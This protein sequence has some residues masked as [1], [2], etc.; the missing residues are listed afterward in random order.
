M[1]SIDGRLKA[2]L[3]AAWLTVSAATIATGADAES[4]WFAIGA[5]QVAAWAGLLRR[6]WREA[7][8]VGLAGAALTAWLVGGRDGEATPLLAAAGVVATALLAAWSHR[9][10]EV[11]AVI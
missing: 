8:A 6:D 7:L 11:T 4:R 3:F 1:L 5:V 9:R 2:C 10:P